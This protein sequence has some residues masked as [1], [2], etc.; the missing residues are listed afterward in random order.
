MS[1]LFVLVCARAF[2]LQADEAALEREAARQQRVHDA[3]RDSASEQLAAAQREMLLHWRT[4]RPAAARAAEGVDGAGAAGGAGGVGDGGQ[5]RRRR[6]AALLAELR[7]VNALFG[8]IH[9]CAEA[10]VDRHFQPPLQPPLPPATAVAASPVSAAVQ[11]QG[12][13]ATD[14]GVQA[15][16]LVEGGGVSDVDDSGCKHRHDDDDDDVDNDSGRAQHRRENRDPASAQRAAPAARGQRQPRR[17]QQP[18]PR[19]L[20]RVRERKAELLKSAGAQHAEAIE[21]RGALDKALR[22][23]RLAWQAGGLRRLTMIEELCQT[24]KAKTKTA[25]ASP[26]AVTPPQH[27]VGRLVR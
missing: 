8:T 3:A 20:A 21:H 24:A 1:C 18:V 2:S 15:S 5:L 12:C 13:A 19:A 22:D 26:A 16:P 10:A 17:H 23:Q 4:A 27:Q 11:D 25:A 9:A 14:S 7:G 6:A